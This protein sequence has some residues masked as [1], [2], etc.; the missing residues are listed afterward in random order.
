MP[1][2]TRVREAAG[3]ASSRARE[4]ARQ[5]ADRV[6][7]DDED[8]RL[9]R[10]KERRQAI[11]ATKERERD[12]PTERV[13]RA[14]QR[15][16]QRRGAGD[17]TDAGDGGPSRRA[18]LRRRAR[19]AARRA[20][21]K[22]RAKAGDLKAKATIVA[23]K[24]REGARGLQR[25][26]EDSGIADAPDS[27]EDQPDTRQPQ[28]QR[29]EQRRPPRERAAERARE[30]GMGGRPAPGP[31]VAPDAGPGLD[32]SAPD[33]EVID[34]D[35]GPPVGGGTPEDPAIDPDEG[36][37]YDATP[38]D[39]GGLNPDDG[40]AVG[41]GAAAVEAAREAGMGGRPDPG[42]T[43]DPDTD[44]PTRVTYTD[45]PRFD[46]TGGPADTTPDNQRQADVIDAIAASEDAPGD[47]EIQFP[48]VEI[49]TD[50]PVADPPT[51][52]SVTTGVTQRDLADGGV[53]AGPSAQV[54]R[55]RRSLMDVPGGEAALAAAPAAVAEP[56]PFGELSLGAAI[57]A[58]TAAAGAGYLARETGLLDGFDAPEIQ[59][60]NAP[61]FDEPEVTITDESGPPSSEIEVTGE[62][63]QPE[64]PVSEGD[65]VGGPEIDPT[66]EVTIDQPEIPITGQED[67]PAE[68]GADESVV[69]GDYPLAGRDFP[70]QE[71]EEFVGTP[72]E[73]PTAQAEQRLLERQRQQDVEERLRD[74]RERTGA[75]EEELEEILDVDP[76]TIGE[77]EDGPTIRREFPTGEGPVVGREVTVDTTTEVD[78]LV[79]EAQELS[80]T[81]SD[82]AP[83]TPPPPPAL[84]RE[85]AE[86]SEVTTETDIEQRLRERTQPVVREQV[87]VRPDVAIAGEL[88]RIQA[89]TAAE[90]TQ[91]QTQAAVTAANPTANLPEYATQPG[92]PTEVVNPTE[93]AFPTETTY[94][95][96][97]SPPRPPDPSADPDPEDEDLLPA[98]GVPLGPYVNPIATAEDVVADPAP[99]GFEDSV[100]AD[101]GGLDTMGDQFAIDPDPLDD[102]GIF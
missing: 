75:S 40:P 16:Q 97:T 35:E 30:T 96:E 67:T 73:D 7:G 94:G 36:P 23:E 82:V 10:V 62:G 98:L 74:Y 3:R 25:A 28:R 53:F 18:R 59:V 48:D 39:G 61:V 51:K 13:E 57:A 45:R 63:E 77:V 80:V 37:Q 78:Q 83:E 93:T 54:R 100:G 19:E 8:E 91:Q 26:A 32:A 24:I 47:E 34:P 11:E 65:P 4:A 21:L 92:Y 90:Q 87:D 101:L 1:I 89:A 55:L 66:S 84:D 29:T 38:T 81:S 50:V 41:Q 20:R 58:G 71:G 72:G 56:T 86:Q 2:T 102:G 9:R 85:Q 76:Q 44:G 17:D 43:V 12:Q 5:A 27:G 68:A 22:R 64:L 69:P 15:L 79:E 70:A 60:P 99:L 52:R 42:P 95:Y 33:A 49:D 46:A 14:K 88:A 6:R 31:T